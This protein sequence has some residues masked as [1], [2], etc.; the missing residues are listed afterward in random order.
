MMNLELWMSPTYGAVPP[1]SRVRD[2]G[3]VAP[4]GRVGWF[5]L[6]NDNST[7]F[8]NHWT[9]LKSADIARTFDWNKD[10]LLVLR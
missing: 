5:I 8:I 3:N 9:Q 6:S 2:Q 7:A 1:L 4:P 10:D